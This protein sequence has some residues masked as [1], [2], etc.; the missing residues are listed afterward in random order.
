M[1]KSVKLALACSLISVISSSFMIGVS[2]KNGTGTVSYGTPV[3][4]GKLDEAYLNSGTETMKRNKFF[5]PWA[6]EKDQESK[7][8]TCKSDATSYFLWDDEYFYTC[9]VV[10]DDQVF[11]RSEE[12][13]ATPYPWQDDGIECIYSKGDETF[14]L[15]TDASGVIV[16]A[17][18]IQKGAGSTAAWADVPDIGDFAKPDLKNRDCKSKFAAALTDDGFI[19][20]TALK[21]SKEDAKY[22]SGDEI[23][24]ALQ[25]NNL[26]DSEGKIGHAIGSQ[27][28]VN[29]G[30][31]LTLG[32]KPADAPEKPSAPATEEKPNAP[33]TSD[34]GIVM[35]AA[36]LV[37]G[38]VFTALKLKKENKT[39]DR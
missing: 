7:A 27:D 19:I 15:H 14:T 13:Y 29:I 31:T 8:D 28:C 5:C 9:T 39:E 1:K 18:N 35:G 4:D 3:I 21:L 17:Y 25:V 26:D 32:E 16:Y 6:P 20:E 22:L 2:A 36:A 11:A 24:F 10:K 37:S 34:A 33:Q 30:I 12:Y 23:K 38:A